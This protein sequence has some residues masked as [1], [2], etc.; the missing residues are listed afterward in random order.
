LVSRGCCWDFVVEENIFCGSYFFERF[1]PFCFWTSLFFTFSSTFHQLILS[2]FF[3]KLSTKAEIPG[4]GF[5]WRNSARTV[6]CSLW[7]RKTKKF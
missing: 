2:C 5:M 7:V 3:R 1:W 6:N 4:N